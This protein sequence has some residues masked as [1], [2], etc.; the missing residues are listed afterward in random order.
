MS[1]ILGGITLLGM[2][3][4]AIAVAPLSVSGNKILA[5]GKPASF[6][7][8]SLFWS[9]VGWGGEKLASKLLEQFPVNVWY[10]FYSHPKWITHPC[11]TYSRWFLSFICNGWTYGAI[12]IAL[13][14]Q[15]LVQNDGSICPT[16]AYEG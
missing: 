7:G 16:I 3:S 12:I 15:V 13:S 2:L 1:K 11:Q 6:S 4:R 14:L 5:S 9:N 8:N 10:T